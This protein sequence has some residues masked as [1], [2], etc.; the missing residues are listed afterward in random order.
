MAA[1]AGLDGARTA[2]LV[3]YDDVQSLCAAAPKLCPLD[4]A[5]T[6]EWLL[7]AGPPI[8]PVVATLAP[9]TDP[10]GIPAPSAPLLEQWQHAHPTHPRR[11]FSA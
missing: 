5:E 11:L 8:D 4:P 10:A 9:L 6:T 1:A 3:A 2:R 7:H